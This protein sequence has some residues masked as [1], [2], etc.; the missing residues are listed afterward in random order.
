[1]GVGVGVT[2]QVEGAILNE[3]VREGL[4][5]EVPFEPRLEADEG[6]SPRL[7]RWPGQSP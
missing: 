7:L 4:L 3:M 6:E 5:G 2:G 1:M